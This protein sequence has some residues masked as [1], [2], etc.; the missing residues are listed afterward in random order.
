MPSEVFTGLGPATF[1][2]APAPDWDDDKCPHHSS[3]EWDSDD[4]IPTA[5]V[6]K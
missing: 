6:V 2:L 4:E 3:S 5:T 1:S